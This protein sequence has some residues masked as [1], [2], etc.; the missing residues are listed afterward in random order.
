[1][2]LVRDEVRQDVPDVQGQ[3]AP[4]VGLRRRHATPPL[5]TQG[6][7]GGD[8]PAAPLERGAQLPRS[9]GPV[10]H[11]RRGDDPMLMAQ[12]PDPR[13]PRVVDMGGDRPDRAARHS[14]DGRR[15][16]GRGDVLDEIARDATVGPP[17]SQDRLVQIERW[18]RG[19]L[20]REVALQGDGFPAKLGRSPPSAKRAARRARRG[21]S[22]RESGGDDPGLAGL[23]VSAMANTPSQGASD[24]ALAWASVRVCRRPCPPPHPPRSPPATRGR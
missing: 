17:G 5:A 4:Y 6:Q 2:R 15:P 11:P 1:M 24:R 13:A 23:G 3:V 12:R 9:D 8:P 19:R 16:E 22:P 18:E 21:R 7:E 20:P 10:I 14:G